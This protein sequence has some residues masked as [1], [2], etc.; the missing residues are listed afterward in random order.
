MP[1]RK[2]ELD[3]TDWRILVEL[4]RDARATYKEIG[5]AVGMTRPAVRERILRLEEAGIISGYHVDINTDAIGR[6]LHVMINFKFDLDNKFDGKPNDSLIPFL[7]TTPEVIRF[8]EIYGELDFLI[9]AAFYTKERMHDFL[10]GLRNFGFVR[11]HLIAMFVK[12]E[13]GQIDNG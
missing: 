5:D 11:T 2:I 8:W 10:D 9:E 3:A 4:Q 7:K 1:N 13:C 6:T 12:R